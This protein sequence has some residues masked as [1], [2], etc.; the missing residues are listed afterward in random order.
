MGDWDYISCGS[1]A[2]T[3]LEGEVGLL[4]P[5]DMLMITSGAV[6]IPTLCANKIKFK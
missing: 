5:C 4:L 1:E 3:G 6:L 2:G